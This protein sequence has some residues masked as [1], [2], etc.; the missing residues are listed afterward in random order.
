MGFLSKVLKTIIAIPKKTVK[1]FIGSVKGT[2]DGDPMAMVQLAAYVYGAYQ[3]GQFLANSAQQ[4]V[5]ATQGA[6][7][8]QSFGMAN[9]TSTS[10]GTV[11]TGGYA[12]GHAAFMG[13]QQSAIGASQMLGSTA[14]TMSANIASPQVGST[15]F[16]NQGAVTGGGGIDFGNLTAGLKSQVHNAP[17]PSIAPQ[18]TSFMGK[19]K[20]AT[21]K[22]T[23]KQAT[24]NLSSNAKQYG[25]KFF[26]DPGAWIRAGAGSAQ[27]MSASQQNAAE[28]QQQ[29]NYTQMYQ[30]YYRQMSNRYKAAGSTV[31]A[32]RYDNAFRSVRS[33]PPS[34]GPYLAY[35][36]GEVARPLTYHQSY[37]QDAI[38]TDYSR[39]A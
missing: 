11:G 14:S 12:P 23:F 16:W 9:V 24:S 8:S 1:G 2:L 7:G 32:Q 10:L 25:K 28:S 26:S 6:A 15:A 39:R 19:F 37:L 29:Q 31:M 22:G 3:G 33:R 21:L 5:L 30:E 13:S 35:M 36:S 18:D 34:F 27:R 20:G 38:N 17:L 4:S